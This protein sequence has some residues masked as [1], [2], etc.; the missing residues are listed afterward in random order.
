MAINKRNAY[1]GVGVFVG[2]VVSLYLARETV[3]KYFDYRTRFYL[4]GLEKGFQKKVVKFLGRARKEGIELRVTSGRRGCW[5]QDR[6]YQQGR[7]TPGKVVT[8]AR[9]GQSA[10][11]Y[12][13]AVDVV[14]FVNGRPVWENPNWE[15]IGQI[16]EGV[17]L[18]W[19]GRWKSFKDR[20]HF[21]DLGGKSIAELYRRYQ[22]TGVLGA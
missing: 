11:N 22:S 7:S 15:R 1:L 8:N 5:E 19:G 6:L 12:G 18:E 9:C 14:E 10:H 21:Q 20:P 2:L 16:G 17:G 4:A 13:L 3:Y